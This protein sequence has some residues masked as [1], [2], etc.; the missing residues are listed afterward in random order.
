MPNWKRIAGTV[1][2]GHRVA[3]GTTKDGPY[4]MGSIAMQT[5]FFLERGLDLRSYFAGTIG[6][7]CASIIFDIADPEY[8]FCGVKWSP[9][10]HAEDFSFSR[11]RIEYDG[12]T[13]DGLVYYPH[14]DTKIGHFH[15]RSTLEILAPFI[16]GIRYG[17]EVK[18]DINPDEITV[19]D[20]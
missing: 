16:R 8:T 19:I 2:E 12:S 3:S 4:P 1:V 5:P 13:Y 17:V 10:H 15:D 20:D 18:L 11:C 9:D 14:P 7:S 6:V